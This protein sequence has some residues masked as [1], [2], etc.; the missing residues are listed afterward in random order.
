MPGHKTTH[1][2]LERFRLIDSILA[3][4]DVLSFENILDSLRLGLRDDLLSDSSLRRDFRYMKNELGAPLAYDKKLH[5]WHYTKP[6]KL[7]AEAFSDDEILYLKL[8]RG[9]VNQNSN[10]DFLYK[11]FDKLLNK[12]I[13]AR[14]AEKETL[15]QVQG[16]SLRHAELVSA[17]IRDRF[18]IAPRPKQLID[19]GVVEKILEAI[20]NNYLLDFN[21]FSKW[22]PE[23]RHRKIMPFQ[24]V[25]DSGS[26]YL[27]AA[28]SNPR[29][30]GPRLYKLSKMHNVQVITSK[31]FDLPANFRFREAFEEGRFG[32]FQY[33]EAYDFKLEFSGEARS[34][35]R[36][37]VWSDNQEI[38]EN[39][40]EGTTVISFTSSQWIPIFRWLLSFGENA[41]PLEPDWF[42]EQWKET[43]RKMSE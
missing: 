28:S 11:A 16:D 24:L 8:I 32:A 13:P 9:L 20:K 39:Q 21:Y 4:G 34:I 19:E 29:V 22:E 40:K 37:C 2:Q 43:V 5:G 38:E 41:R 36:E 14:H 35:V 31:T 15:K 6:F 23:E 30:P 10:D 18:Y 42:V 1:S 27:Y 26:M 3:G 25:F 33:D 17:S 7:P 12:I